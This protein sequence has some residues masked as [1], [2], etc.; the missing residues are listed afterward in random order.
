MLFGSYGTSFKKK[1]DKETIDPF[2]I[3]KNNNNTRSFRFMEQG[4]NN[5]LKFSKK[6]TSYK[7]SINMVI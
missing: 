5:F 7:P 2:F 3:L 1:K 6:T 4:N